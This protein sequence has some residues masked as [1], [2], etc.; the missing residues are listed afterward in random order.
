MGRRFIKGI[1]KKGMFDGKEIYVEIGDNAINSKVMIGGKDV[2]SSV[3]AI[4]FHMDADKNNG[5]PFVVIEW[6]GL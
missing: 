6:V 4:H 3:R 5:I 2:S 1:V